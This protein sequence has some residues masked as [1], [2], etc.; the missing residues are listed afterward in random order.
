MTYQIRLSI[1]SYLH[2]GVGV[3]PVLLRPS[4]VLDGEFRA[5]VQAAEAHDA[6][7][8][9]PDGPP[10]PH[11]DGLHGAF[12]GAQPAADAAVLHMEMLRAP[13]PFVDRPGDQIRENRRRAR[14]HAPADA[15]R[16]KRCLWSVSRVRPGTGRALLP[17]P[18]GVGDSVRQP[19]ALF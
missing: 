2:I 8:A 15:A 4:A 1:A 5:A 17:L 19:V 9:H 18:A 6:L 3:L 14:K 12:P 10:V 13:H 11:L 7:I 16:H